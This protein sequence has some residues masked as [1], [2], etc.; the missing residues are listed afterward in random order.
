MK[1]AFLPVLLLLL[2]AAS[3]PVFAQ[4]D[5]TAEQQDAITV[6]ADAMAALEELNSY[7]LHSEQLIIQDME[8]TM[9]EQAVTITND[10]TQTLDFVMMKT[11]DGYNV[12]GSMEQETV[13]ESGGQSSTLSLTFELVLVDGEAYMRVSG[14]AGPMSSMLPEGWV[15]LDDPALVGNPLLA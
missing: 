11:E 13:T 7:S 1:R 14:D 5:L 12:S 8:M 2:L 15:S 3:L 10:I 4:G 9:G 6:V